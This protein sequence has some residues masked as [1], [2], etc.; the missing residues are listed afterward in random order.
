M[1]KQLYKITQFHGGLNSN[2]DPR[3]I[4]ENELSDAT[5]VMVDELGKIRT[6]GGTTAHTAGI[7]SDD[8]TGWTGTTVPGHGLFQFSHDRLGAEDAGATENETGDDYLAIY[9]DND[10]QIWVYSRV[11]D[12]WND[13]KD[14]GDTGII[15]LGSTGSAKPAFYM[16]D[17]ALRISDGAFGANNT[18]KWYGY[19][20]KVHFDIGSPY[21]DTYDGWYSEN[22]AIASPTSG[23]IGTNT[24]LLMGGAEGTDDDTLKATGFFALADGTAVTTAQV[25]GQRALNLSEGKYADINTATSIDVL[26]TDSLTASGNWNTEDA[27]MI[28]PQP[29]VG[30]NVHVSVGEGISTWTDATYELSSTFIYDGNQESLPFTLASTFTIS[31]DNDLPTFTVWATSPYSS[32]MLGARIYY[33]VAD[34]PDYWKLLI[35]ISMKDGIRGGLLDAYDAWTAVSNPTFYWENWYATWDGLT[36]T[37]D[38]TGDRWEDM[39]APTF[40][41][42]FTSAGTYLQAQQIVINPDTI[43]IYEILS[44]VSQEANT[45]EAKFATAIVANRLVYI[46][47]IQTKN[48]SNQD[49][50][51]GDAM[52]K[53]PVNKVDMFPLNRMIEVSVRDGDEIVKLETY[54]DRLL[55]F[56]KKKMHLINISQE[57][58]FLEDTFMYKG[59]SHPAS[60]CKT[61]FGIAWA[62][63]NGCYLYNG[64]IIINLLEKESGRIIKQ[65]EW[66]NF[67]TAGKD[68][69]GTALDP[70]VGY[71]PKKRQLIIFD[72]ITNTS[73]ADPRMYIYDM[74][75]Q[76]WT[77][78][79]QDSS[80]RNID[81]AK[82]N[83]VTDWDGDLLYAHTNGTLLKWDD[84]SDATDTISFKTKDVDFGQPGVRKK[85]YKVY[86]SYKGDGSSVNIQYATNGDNDT[87]APFYRTQADGSTDG[88][89]SDT[90]PLLNV[91]TDDWV[92]GELKPVSSISNIYSFQLIFDGTA[93]ADF[94]I[95]DISI[96]Y[97]MKG[98]R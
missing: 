17:G 85:V 43:N 11:G 70:M 8:V 28:F 95:N 47:N 96:V 75:T 55:Q 38:N 6:M 15:D 37:T 9:D 30:F 51:F 13:D 71:L 16:M 49:E 64:E 33:R 98:I 46:G 23:L 58:E 45:L 27:F 67:L 77:K 54:A 12:T 34:S 26:E 3:D 50:V 41:S 86:I 83:F 39:V 66:T 22:Q 18:N 1:P 60:V 91:G 89:N 7:P 48:D 29:G 32:R 87:T 42:T 56:K 68:G 52:I 62:N 19:I 59:V 84:T 4:A 82:T 24:E 90:T 74:A 80:T 2:S 76:S 88:S 36:D 57:V 79:A 44:G 81:V 14:A 97:R 63:T 25:S 31:G 20:D 5:D 35:D 78:G 93:A 65:S 94:E 61:D 92:P 69:S 72:D 21:V 73:T 53:T 10:Q 40:H